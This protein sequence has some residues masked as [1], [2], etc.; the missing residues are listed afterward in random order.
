MNLAKFLKTP[1]L[2]NTSERL[3]L[4]LAFQKQPP[5]VFYEKRCSWISQN[6]QEK[7]FGLQNFQK[8]LF[9]RTPLDD[10]F[11]LF[12][13]T[14]LKW[15]TANN[16]RKTSDEYSISRNTN[17]RSTVQVHHFFFWQDK[18][19]VYVFIGLHYLL[20]EA[21]IRV[22]LFCKKG[23]L[24]DFIN[25]I[26]K[27]LCWSLFL[28]KLQVWHLFRGTSANDW[29][30]TAFAPLIVTYPFYFIFST[31][32]LIITA[33]TVTSP[34][35]VFGSKTSKASKNLNLVSHFHWTHFHSCYFLFQCFFVFLSFVSFFLAH[36]KDQ[37]Y[38]NTRAPT[39]VN[40]S[41]HEFNTSPTRA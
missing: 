36:K 35:F 19:S 6:L 7:I 31:F 9:Y 22:K 4:L 1:F 20:P 39:Q 8:H 5:E 11:W 21:A 33:T 2:Q 16:V 40:T 27:H 17:L 41:Q 29:F 12:R 30:C 18:L 23:V 15:G 24:K 10:C 37:V 34:V 14:L 3:L 13:A 28:I 25:F 38:S 32:F 26:G